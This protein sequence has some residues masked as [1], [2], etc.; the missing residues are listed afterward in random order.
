MLLFYNFGYYFNNLLEIFYIWQGGMSFHGGMIG[1]TLAVLYHAKKLQKPFLAY[2]DILALAVPI[3]LF[4]GR[5]ANFINGELYGRV[6][7]V[8]WAVIFPEAGLV[9]RHPTQ[10]YEAFFEGLVA[11]IILYYLYSKAN[12]F[13]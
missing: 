12:F 13:S 5:I 10:L 11:F 7:S 2:M 6:T 9:A 1:F 8:K 3:G 4:F